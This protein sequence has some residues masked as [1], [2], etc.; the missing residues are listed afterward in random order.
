MLA[1]T[2]V[3]YGH[4]FGATSQT[5]REPFYHLF[6]IG[7]G[8]I[9]VDCFFVISGFLIAKSFAGKDVVHFAWARV[10]RI[11]PALWI[12]SI[13]L[14]VVAGLVFSPLGAEEFWG[15]HDTLTY[16][17][18]NAT[19]LPGVGAQTHLPYAF[20]DHT[21]AFNES[22]WTLP[23]ELQMYM[24]LATL[25]LLGLLAKPI[26]ACGV[27]LLGAGAFSAGILGL[28]HIMDID[29]ARFLYFFFT[30]TAFFLLSD[31]VRLRTWV[32]LIC[33]GA[34]LAIGYGTTNHAIHRLVL[35]AV[36]PYLVLWFSFVPR[37]SIRLYN[38][39]GDYSYGTY[40]L[41]GPIQVLLALRLS[42]STPFMNF[43]CT[44][45]ILIPLAALSWHFVESRALSL[46]LP[47]PLEPLARL[48]PPRKT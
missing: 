18:K 39:L 24:L 45:L 41:A 44:M 14:V 6:G 9:G 31:H 35:A 7:T 22:L 23:H 42:P 27:A 17:A 10:M 47:A 3:V 32:S 33:I 38:R 20:D 5:F 26:S 11:F 28:I 37:G 34:C 40:I 1:A 25:G 13:C 48:L 29:R 43:V 46:R 21:S 4:A 2:A 16:L 30:G 36:I 19:M 15:R 8:D 12:T